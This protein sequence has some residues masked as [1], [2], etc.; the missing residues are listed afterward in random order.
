MVLYDWCASRGALL[1]KSSNDIGT[2]IDK[3]Q[4]NFFEVILTFEELATSPVCYTRLVTAFMQGALFTSGGCT[5]SKDELI[6]YTSQERPFRSKR[7][8]QHNC[9]AAML[10]TLKEHSPTALGC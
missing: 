7:P 6:C 9:I 3:R 5:R 1:G 4:T 8:G 2:N 10:K